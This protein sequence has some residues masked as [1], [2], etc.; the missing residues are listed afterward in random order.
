MDCSPFPFSATI[1]FE[2]IDR[3]ETQPSFQY[4]HLFYIARTIDNFWECS[5]GYVERG[6][7][8]CIQFV[9]VSHLLMNATEREARTR[10][11]NISSNQPSPSNST[12][13]SS[14]RGECLVTLHNYA[15]CN[16]IY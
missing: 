1:S 3:L 9:T 14:C 5:S 8:A 6:N 15:V 10:V 16:Y 11:F 4:W 2:E 7:S 12:V 13:V